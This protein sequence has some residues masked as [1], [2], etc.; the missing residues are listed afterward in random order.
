MQ[1]EI[2]PFYDSSHKNALRW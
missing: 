1:K 2:A